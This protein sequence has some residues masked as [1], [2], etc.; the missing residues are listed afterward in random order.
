MACCSSWSVPFYIEVLDDSGPAS[1]TAAID[2]GDP[3]TVPVAFASVNAGFFDQYGRLLS[4]SSLAVGGSIQA[5][6]KFTAYPPAAIS[7]GAYWP[8]LRVGAAPLQIRAANSN[9]SAVS[10]SLQDWAIAPGNLLV[11]GP[12]S[13]SAVAG[14][15]SVISAQ[16][17]I[18]ASAGNSQPL[19]VDVSSNQLT[20]GS[21]TIG[22]NLQAVLAVTLPSLKSP[23][24]VT[25]TSADPSRLVLSTDPTKPGQASVTVPSQYGFQV[26]AQALAGSGNVDVS[27]TLAGV[28][29]VHATVHLAPSGFA[30]SGEVLNITT[31]DTASPT[32]QGYLLDAT[33]YAPVVAQMAAPSVG[34]VSLQ[35]PGGSVVTL[36][37]TSVA[38]SANSLATPVPLTA[39]GVGTA[40]IAILQPPGC[41]VPTGR[42][43]LRVTVTLPPFTLSAVKVGKYLQLPVSTQFPKGAPPSPLPPISFASADSSKLLVSATRTDPGNST[44]VMSVAATPYTG[45]AYQPVYVQAIGG[46]ADVTLTASMA[47]HT[48]ASTVVQIVPTALGISSGYYSSTTLETN[49][50]ASPTILTLSAVALGGGSGEF[51]PGFPSSPVTI[52]DSNPAVASIAPGPIHTFRK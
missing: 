31:A 49:T 40:Q 36:A 10:T 16:W 18:A 25:L 34:N 12:E 2:G 17:S 29:S 41:I 7:Y 26:Y 28:P 19:R 24:A 48:D 43:A 39:A 5:W 15:S 47:G 50:Q 44:A 3:V 45:V 9:P 4:E 30:W 27:A 33:S 37:S 8:Y 22:V 11:T 51:W 6:L 52:D 38:L 23:A 21:A 32:I 35:I 20:L 1:L 42:H 13:L 46:P 14:G